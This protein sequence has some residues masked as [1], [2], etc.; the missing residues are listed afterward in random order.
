MTAMALL[1]HLNHFIEC[2]DIKQTILPG[3][4]GRRNG[5][6]RT[7]TH[8]K[9]MKQPT[10][11]LNRHKLLSKAEVLS[12]KVTIWDTWAKKTSS[13][14]ESFLVDKKIFKARKKVEQFEIDFLVGCSSFWSFNRRSKNFRRK[15][16][17]SRSSSSALAAENKLFNNSRRLMRFESLKPKEIGTTV[18]KENWL[19]F[20]FPAKHVFVKYFQLMSRWV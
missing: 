6:S 1:P 13:D 16:R 10:W 15:K 9:I 20:R 19:F 4:I 18:K 2:S 8:V 17:E 11:P 5:V 3:T 7:R 12:K 14:E